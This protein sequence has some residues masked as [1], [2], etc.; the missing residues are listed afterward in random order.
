MVSPGSDDGSGA[1]RLKPLKQFLAGLEG[2]QRTQERQQRCPM[3]ATFD[4]ASREPVRQLP[5]SLR[6]CAHS[7]VDECTLWRCGG[8]LTAAETHGGQ[9]MHPKQT[10]IKLAMS[11]LHVRTRDSPSY[12]LLFWAPICAVAGRI[13]FNK[14][15]DA[16]LSITGVRVCT[17]D[18]RRSRAGHNERGQQA[19]MAAHGGSAAEAQGLRRL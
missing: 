15:C 14:Q 4:S 8:Q 1:E 11:L 16:W 18:Q 3:W 10:A 12:A 2:K 7:V 5:W 9:C 13:S 19:P 17:G 6:P